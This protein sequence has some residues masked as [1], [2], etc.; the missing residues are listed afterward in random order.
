MFNNKLHVEAR[1]VGGICLSLLC[2]TAIAEENGLTEQAFLE[3]FPV[4]LS[5]SRLVQPVSEAPNAVTVIDRDMI[6]S[7][8]FRNIGDLFR[9]VPGMYV[10]NLNG[11]TPVVS[12]HGSTEEFSR[13]M[14]VLIDGRSVY[15]PPLSTVDWEDIPLHIADIERIEVV[16]GPA[17]ASYGANSL[18]GVIN[19]ITRDASALDGFRGKVTAGDFGVADAAVRF[20]RNAETLDYRMTLAHREDSG[21]GS[22]IMND[23]RRTDQANL[24]ANYHPAGSGSFDFQLGYSYST[25]GLGLVGRPDEPFR[26]TTGISSFQQLAW[27]NAVQEGNEIKVQYYHISL[28]KADPRFPSLNA[29]SFVQASTEAERHD[30][31][32]QQT[33][34]WNSN[35]RMV[36]G[37]GSRQDYA[38]SREVLV[39]PYTIR[40]TRIFAH[41]EWRFAS[42]ALLNIGNML[43]DDGLGHVNNSPRLAVNY[44]ITPHHTLRAGTS[45]AYRTPAMYEEHVN[46]SGNNTGQ[47]GS[48]VSNGGL[49]PEK[50]ISRE[51]GYMGEFAGSGMSLE[52]RGYNDQV[53]DV[54]FVDPQASYYLT[55]GDFWPYGFANLYSINYTGYESTLRYRWSDTGNVIVSAARQFARCEITGAPTVGALTP[56]LQGYMDECPLAVPDYSGSILLTQGLPDNF[57][58]SA[59]FYHSGRIKMLAAVPQ[60]TMNR[61]DLRIARKFGKVSLPGSG[62]IALVVQNAFNDDYTKY[63][64]APETNNMRY[65]SRLFVTAAYVF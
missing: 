2:M 23:G 44:H 6:R 9:L 25:R 5:A 55:T 54:I 57:D 15:M 47:V 33:L 4:V 28:N 49:R 42:S 1:I 56:V 64:I 14:Q 40:Q 3:D 27:T 39:T 35:N 58:V 61:V 30:A 17:A 31:E 46:I 26:N 21:Y 8:G 34:Q 29:G 41:D 20:G 19:I 51:I 12:Y 45:V 24:R 16:R 11:Y 48:Y 63:S 53:S 38:S 59:G 52:I 65:Q 36:W 22:S 37:V 50:S 62:E 7:S 18:Q 10:G 60:S 13:R 43:E 32:V